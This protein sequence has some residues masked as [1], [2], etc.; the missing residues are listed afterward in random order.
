MCEQGFR[1]TTN[2]EKYEQ[3]K[4]PVIVTKMLENIM[5]NRRTIQKY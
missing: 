3:I 4:V 2:T 1:V 5:E